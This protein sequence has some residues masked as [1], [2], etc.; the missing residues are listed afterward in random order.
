MLAL[1]ST[2]HYSTVYILQR[3][4]KI[5]NHGKT[6]C[7]YYSTNPHIDRKGQLTKYSRV[8]LTLSKYTY[9]QAMGYTKVRKI[10]NYLNNKKNHSLILSLGTFRLF[11]SSYSLHKLG[12]IISASLIAALNAGVTIIAK[13]WEW[14]TMKCTLSIQFLFVQRTKKSNARNHFCH[15]I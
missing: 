8:L 15:L 3:Y 11:L 5:V 6:I 7:G 1:Y 2:S 10:M 13:W 12:Q 9:T 14:M 4:I